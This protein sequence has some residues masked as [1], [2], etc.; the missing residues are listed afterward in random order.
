MHLLK[1]DFQALGLR[2]DMGEGLLAVH[3]DAAYHHIIC[4]HIDRH[5]LISLGEDE[6]AYAAQYIK[7][8]KYGEPNNSSRAE[9]ED[10]MRRFE[11]EGIFAYD[12]LTLHY[13]GAG[14]IAACHPV[15]TGNAVFQAQGLE[16]SEIGIPIAYSRPATLKDGIFKG[17]IDNAICVATAYALFENGYQGTALFAC[18]EEI[19]KSWLHIAAYLEQFNLETQNLLVLDTSPYHYEEPIDKGRVIFRNRDFSEGFNP[20]LVAGLTKRCEALGLLYQMKDEFLLSI[21]K[22]IHQIGS[23]ELGRLIQNKAGRWSGATIQIPTM[24]YHTS[25]ETTSVLAIDNFYKFLSNILI[26]DPLKL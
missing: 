10:I 4:A 24:M 11:G 12:P 1:R 13:H 8:I 17:Q 3:G 23:T 20:A 21:G 19:G 5:G 18:E 9:L 14:T 2:V 22:E 16:L 26:E 7:E 6:Y 25:S 15:E